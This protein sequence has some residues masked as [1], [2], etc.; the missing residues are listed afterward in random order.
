MFIFLTRIK[1]IAICFVQ[2]LRHC[3]YK[4]YIAGKNKM[5]LASMG[6]LNYYLVFN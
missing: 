2:V 3:N 6:M 4:T 5:L 1:H